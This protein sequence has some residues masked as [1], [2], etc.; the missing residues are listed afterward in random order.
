MREGV[1]MVARCMQHQPEDGT[2]GL[3]HLYD[4]DAT[5]QLLPNLYL[6]TEKGSVLTQAVLTIKLA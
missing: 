2:I 3:A 4:V 5:Q 1:A 6:R